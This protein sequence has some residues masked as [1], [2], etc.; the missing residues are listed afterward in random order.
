MRSSARSCRWC[1]WVSWVN[2]VVFMG[3]VE[4]SGGVRGCRFTRGWRRGGARHG[5]ARLA[6]AVVVVVAVCP[7]SCSAPIVVHRDVQA[8]LQILHPPAQHLK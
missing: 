8:Q 5:G 3:V 6:S 7:A 2:L 1:S 4:K